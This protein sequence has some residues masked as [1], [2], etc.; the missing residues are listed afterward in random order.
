MRDYL[1][2]LLELA[3]PDEE[4]EVREELEERL[5]LP[6]PVL[7]GELPE[8]DRPERPETAQERGLGQA[9]LDGDMAQIALDEAEPAGEYRADVLSGQTE[10]ARDAAGLV[11]QAPGRSEGTDV[12]TGAPQ[13]GTTAAGGADRIETVFF[14]LGEP[15]PAPRAGAVLDQAGEAGQPGVLLGRVTWAEQAALYRRAPLSPPVQSE[16]GRTLPVERSVTTAQLGARQIDRVFERD[17]RR[18]DG[19]FTLY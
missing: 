8:R 4:R 13:A 15:A 1:E 7:A 12:V 10:R 18:Y 2:E 11:G 3:G 14:Q 19:E 17:A 16:E 9:A 6:G 5:E